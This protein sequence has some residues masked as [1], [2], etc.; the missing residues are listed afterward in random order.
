[1]RRDC[2][3]HLS[4]TSYQSPAKNGTRVQARSLVRDAGPDSGASRASEDPAGQPIMLPLGQEVNSWELAAK[5]LLRAT[6][7]HGGG[8]KA[9]E[10]K[11]CRYSRRSRLYRARRR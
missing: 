6:E 3:K 7:P 11:L 9:Y 10:C 5:A 4:V 2:L 8:G 1:L